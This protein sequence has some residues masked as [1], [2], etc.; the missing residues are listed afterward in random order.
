MKVVRYGIIIFFVFFSQGF[1]SHAHLAQA[2]DNILTEALKENE[3]LFF[4]DIAMTLDAE[5]KATFLE[6]AKDA[7]VHMVQS[8]AGMIFT[9]FELTTKYVS[10]TFMEGDDNNTYLKVYSKKTKKTSSYG[11]SP[12]YVMPM[13]ALAKKI[14]NKYLALGK[15]N[16]AQS[17]H[18]FRLVARNEDPSKEEAAKRFKKAL[19]EAK[20]INDWDK[21]DEADYIATHLNKVL[22]V[23]RWKF[24]RQ[25]SV[26]DKKDEIKALDTLN[27]LQDYKPRESDAQLYPVKLPKEIHK[28]LT[29]LLKVDA[30]RFADHIALKNVKK[31]D[32]ILKKSFLQDWGFKMEFIM[33]NNAYFINMIHYPDTETALLFE[34]PKEAFINLGLIKK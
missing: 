31:F 16:V 9:Y 18:K 24:M 34:V 3:K 20:M 10:I 32:L 27:L 21:E 33:A 22:G 4:A 15:T 17:V 14:G 11:I 5:D 25:Y 8:Y 28:N 1:L 26:T 6:I 12:H 23:V 29:S 7:K 2:K 19:E 30:W 13:Y